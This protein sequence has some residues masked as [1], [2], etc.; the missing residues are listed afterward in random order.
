M[1]ECSSESFGALAEALRSFKAL[2]MTEEY[3]EVY[4]EGRERLRELKRG[5]QQ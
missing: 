1:K 2:D 3:G 5:A 4:A